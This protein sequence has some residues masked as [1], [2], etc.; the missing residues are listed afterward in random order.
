MTPFE[1]LKQSKSTG[2]QFP[3]REQAS[4]SQSSSSSSSVSFST[5]VRLAEP[6]GT[7]G[8]RPVDFFDPRFAKGSVRRGGGSSSILS[9]I[10]DVAVCCDFFP[11]ALLDVAAFC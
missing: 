3:S 6:S 8:A 1:F 5:A 11:A 2:M 9:G 4:I 7:V 10:L